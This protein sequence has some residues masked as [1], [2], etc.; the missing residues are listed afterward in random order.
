MDDGVLAVTSS[1]RRDGRHRPAAVARA[2]ARPPAVDVPRVQAERAVVAMPPA[3]RQR[4]DE[5][6]AVP[7]A[8]L[9]AGSSAT[10]SRAV[11][12]R[13]GHGGSSLGR[14]YACGVRPVQLGEG[15]GSVSSPWAFACCYSFLSIAPGRCPRGYVHRRG[16]PPA[17]GIARFGR[18]TRWPSRMREPP[19]EACTT[20]SDE[21]GRE[22][23]RARGRE[24]VRPRA[25][26]D[27]RHGRRRSG[28]RR[29]GDRRNGAHRLL[30][31]RTSEHRNSASPPV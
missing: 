3:R 26:L 12:V 11:S 27:G 10:A 16:A 19:V 1:E 24:G 23:R 7:A 6:P 15:R 17:R 9:I 20:G 4:A 5:H 31:S 22:R 13:V 30:L 18:R 29:H 28:E 25:A 8:E 21:K 14:T 2:V